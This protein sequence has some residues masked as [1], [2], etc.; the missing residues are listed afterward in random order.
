MIITHEL[1]INQLFV[2]ID[3]KTGKY[4]AFQWTKKARIM[5]LTLFLLSIKKVIKN[6]NGILLHLMGRPLRTIPKISVREL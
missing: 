6:G 2:Y 3:L 4:Y 5:C 1:I